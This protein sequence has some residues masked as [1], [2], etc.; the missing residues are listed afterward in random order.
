MNRLFCRAILFSASVT[1]LAPLASAQRAYDPADPR[2]DFLPHRF[3]QSHV[4]YRKA[5]NRPRYTI[6]HLASWFEPTSQE[7]MSWRDSLCSGAYDTTCPT[8]IPFYHYPKPWEILDVGP[9]RDSS[10][11]PAKKTAQEPSP[12]NQNDDASSDALEVNPTKKG[13]ESSSFF[14]K[15]KENGVLRA[16][17]TDPSR[18]SGSKS[19][20]Q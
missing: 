11:A 1:C 13:V 4:E 10:L 5:Y 15:N 2:P 8:P 14:L 20:Y 19:P 16:T 9:R 7:A 17:A 12:S 6:G 18:Y 3:Y